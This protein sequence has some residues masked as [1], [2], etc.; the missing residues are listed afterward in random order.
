MRSIVVGTRGSL[1]ALAQ[2][3]QIVAAL[4]QQHPGLDIR[5]ETISTHGDQKPDVPLAQVGQKG[6]FSKELETALL[7]RRIDLAVHSAK[8][9]PAPVP[10]GLAILC[11]PPREDPRDALIQGSGSR[12]QGSGFPPRRAGRVQDVA[13]P[14]ATAGV[15]LVGGAGARALGT[16]RRS[17]GAGPDATEALAGLNQGAVVGTSSLRR[18][19]QLA[20]L[21]RDLRFTLLRGNVETRIAKVRRGE[22]DATVLALAGLKRAGLAREAAAILDIDVMIPAPGQGALALEGRSDD[23]ELADLLRPLHDPDSALALRCER[24]V[25]EALG[26]TCTTPIGVLARV[27]HDRL[28]LVAVVAKPD[29]M[30]AARAQVAGSANDSQRLVEQAL[31]RLSAQKVFEILASCG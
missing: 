28:Q 1:L 3:R 18:Q 10:D 17:A 21:R 22:C 16:S 12:G 5:V 23:A 2:T 9:L 24:A 30:S 7:E 6:I 14:P 13:S 11:V 31:A 8:D 20:L 27:E 26:A 4:R 25:V 29:G 15:P 19:A